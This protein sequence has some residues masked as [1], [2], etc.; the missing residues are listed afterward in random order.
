MNE[1]ETKILDEKKNIRNLEN[2]I[3]P[4]QYNFDQYS[5]IDG[6]LIK[7]CDKIAAFLE[8]YFSII[9]GVASPQLI[10]AK[11]KL[12]NELKDRKLDGIDIFLIIDL[13][14]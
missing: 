7:T 5:P 12:F 13:F 9:N 14:R 1:F 10:E 4:N 3:I 2:E 6:K 8:T 11:G